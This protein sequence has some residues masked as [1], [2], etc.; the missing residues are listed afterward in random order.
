MPEEYCPQRSSVL[1][2]K[3]KNQSANKMHVVEH[4]CFIK[5]KILDRFQR[6]VVG[7][8]YTT[9]ISHPCLLISIVYIAFGLDFSLNM[10]LV[11]LPALINS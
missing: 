1:K 4:A 10:H 8:R 2:K 11:P 7:T 6:G 9:N 3:K 5:I